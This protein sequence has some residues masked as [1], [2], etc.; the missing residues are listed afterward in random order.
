MKKIK[1]AARTR[2]TA[3]K[4]AVRINTELTKINIETKVKNT[5]MMMKR[6]H[7]PRIKIVNIRTHLLKNISL[8]TKIRRD[9]KVTRRSIRVINIPT[10]KTSTGNEYNVLKSYFIRH[11]H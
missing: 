6:S 1:T 2:S 8:K 7:P 3:I 10:L 4:N 5:K 9:T 11:P